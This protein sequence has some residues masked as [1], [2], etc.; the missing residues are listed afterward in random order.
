MVENSSGLTLVDNAL[1]YHEGL[2]FKCTGCGACCESDGMVELS[3]EDVKNGAKALGISE[4]DFLKTYT[5]TV[6]RYRCLKD[7]PGT[8]KCIFLNE[9][10]GCAIYEAR[11]K[12]CR[13]FPFWK[14]L[15]RSKKA[16]QQERV[17]CEG[18]DHPDGRLYTP[19]EIDQMVDSCC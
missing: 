5:E 2:S 15:V 1:W 18:L 14:S 13:T 12:Q 16:W 8:T 19:E 7:Q 9:D 10:K 17:R 3:A 11:P 6:S 4:S